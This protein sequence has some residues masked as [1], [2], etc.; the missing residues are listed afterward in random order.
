MEKEETR[1]FSDIKKFNEIYK[2]PANKKPTLLSV[3]R[4]ENF[5]AILLEE[6]NEIDEIVEAYKQSR[7]N[8]TDEQK[9]ELLTM[10]SDWLGDMVVYITSEATKH[11]LDLNKTLEII[12]ESNFSKLGKDGKPIYDERGKVMKGPD[13]WKPEPKIKELLKSFD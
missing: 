2:L 9:L 1:F 11:G 8:L 7:E 10:L 6:I 3:E 13:Y 4:L 5:K 12:M